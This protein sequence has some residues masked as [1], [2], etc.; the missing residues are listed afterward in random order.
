MRTLGS[1]P[2]VFLGLTASA[3]VSACAFVTD[4]G[5]VTA[6]SGGAGTGASSSTGGA[7]GAGGTGGTGAGPSCTEA[8]VDCFA[9]STA[10]PAP[11][12]DTF[13]FDAEVSSPLDENSVRITDAFFS[14]LG[15]PR[16]VGSFI[17]R[18]G[19][20]TLT[21]PFGVLTGSNA[22]GFLAKEDGEIIGAAGKCNDDNS[23]PVLGDEVFFNAGTAVDDT[24]MNS[25]VVAVGAFEA[26]H[27]RFYDGD[28][29]CSLNGTGIDSQ[30]DGMNFTPFIAWMDSASGAPQR[31]LA[32]AF[33]S[34]TDLGYLSDVA[35]L[36]SNSP[37]RVAAIGV[38]AVRPFGPV[39]AFQDGFTYYVVS[40]N[41]I[42]APQVLPLPFHPCEANHYKGLSG[43]RSSIAVNQGTQVWVAGTG[44]AAP[45][46]A[47]DHPRRSF[48]GV[49]SSNDGALSMPTA[50]RS[51]G[52]GDPSDTIAISEVAVSDGW[53][54]VA[55][56]YTGNPVE[57]A[58]SMPTATGSDDGFVMGFPRANWDNG[59]PPSW[60][61]RIASDGGPGDV[62]ALMIDNGRV[63]LAGDLADG[64]G[65]EGAQAC[66]TS[67]SLGRG[68]AV[69]AQLD[70][71]TGALAWMR[72]DG[73][74]PESGGTL[75]NR[76]ASGTAILAD[77]TFVVTVTSTH[78]EVDLGCTGGSTGLGD[79]PRSTVRA[80]M[81][82]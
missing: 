18:A 36:P 57:L 15:E 69:F 31:S 56:N 37:G 4:F 16:Y 71:A 24:P 74:E 17:D 1:R 40:S 45:I 32:P 65:I 3:L 62:H 59:V 67:Q 68:R 46:A 9:G 49:L 29:D 64:G 10:C 22:A 66:F 75:T 51:F 53:V 25:K 34:G 27:V 70:E 43:L 26:E 80:F 73:F 6:L 82:P 19:G 42:V 14:T 77:A 81:L 30:D 63:F 39:G 55:G 47:V 5:D 20:D 72:V 50:F 33:A 48:L 54:V 28:L 52:N 60:F 61:V 41:G 58:G 2:L 38:A 44:C 7:G 35:A 76:F 79:K 8:C 23:T 11:A 13:F 21:H 78:G 12:V